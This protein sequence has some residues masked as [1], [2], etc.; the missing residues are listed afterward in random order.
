[1]IN[2]FNHS[3]NKDANQN[4]NVFLKNS[5]ISLSYFPIWFFFT[6]SPLKDRCFADSI[7]SVIG[8]IFGLQYTR[9]NSRTLDQRNFLENTLPVIDLLLTLFQWRFYLKNACLLLFIWKIILT[10]N[11]VSSTQTV[12]C[13]TAEW[14]EIWRDMFDVTI[15][16]SSIIFVIWLT[17]WQLYNTHRDELKRNDFLQNHRFNVREFSP[18]L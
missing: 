14:F 10:R 15:F 9:N 17:I 16:F 5:S 3:K 7:S 13:C 18:F 2:K 6:I 12:D 1:M 11:F 8:L 4:H